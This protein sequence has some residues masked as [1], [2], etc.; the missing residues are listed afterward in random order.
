MRRIQKWQNCAVRNRATMRN[1]DQLCFFKWEPPFFIADSDS[2]SNFMNILVRQLFFFGRAQPAQ[3]ALK[4]AQ[5][6]DCAKVEMKVNLKCG[7]SLST[8]FL[9]WIA[10][11]Y[12]FLDL[13]SFYRIYSRKSHF[14]RRKLSIFRGIFS[15]NCS[16]LELLLLCAGRQYSLH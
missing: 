16:F 1:H 9:R 3:R 4:D 7:T 10:W 11:W 5:P 6:R 14:L 13:I 8:V 15:E 12:P 2:T